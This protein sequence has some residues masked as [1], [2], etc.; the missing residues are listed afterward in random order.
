MTSNRGTLAALYTICGIAIAGLLATGIGSVVIRLTCGSGGRPGSIIAGLQ[1]AISGASNAYTL[2]AGC[3]PSDVAV[4]A[5]D[6]G[7]VVLLVAA[8]AVVL[9]WWLRY[10]QSD[11][12]FI[13]DL[14]TRD[15]F[16]KPG[17]IRRHVSARAVTANTRTLRPSATT[18]A[19]ASSS[20]PPR[21]STSRATAR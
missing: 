9:G 3:A 15:G 17:E 20:C 6:I 14:K 12:Y 18:A 4:R 7:I 21:A 8:G 11:R 1:W 16:A 13:H 10:R 2:P 5:A 19:P